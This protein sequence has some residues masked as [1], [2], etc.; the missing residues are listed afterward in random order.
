MESSKN[1]KFNRQPSNSSQW[2]T[3]QRKKFNKNTANKFTKKSANT[4]SSTIEVDHEN[5]KNIS[6]VDSTV[7]PT[8]KTINVNTSNLTNDEKKARSKLWLD[9]RNQVTQSYLDFLS[10]PK[11]EI[12]DMIAIRRKMIDRSTGEPYTYIT[13]SC[14]AYDKHQQLMDHVEQGDFTFVLN[15]FFTTRDRNGKCYFTSKL[16][17]YYKSLGYNLGFIS[18]HDKNTGFNN[19]THL[20]VYFN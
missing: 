16:K 20:K 1:N 3:V 15:Q 13:I 9:A 17:E 5:I 14:K 2:H 10:Y 19:Y 4:N 7:V 11:N 12:E 6:N 18:K 8:E